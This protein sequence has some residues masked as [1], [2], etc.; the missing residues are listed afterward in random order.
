ML[1]LLYLDVFKT[2]EVIVLQFPRSDGNRDSLQ[3]ALVWL[4][5]HVKEICKNQTSN[6]Q[7]DTFLGGQF[8]RSN[9]V[10]SLWT[11]TLLKNPISRW[12]WYVAFF[13]NLGI[14][15]PGCRRKNIADALFAGGNFSNERH[16]VVFCGRKTNFPL[17]R[18]Y[19][20]SYK[21]ERNKVIKI[22]ERS[23]PT[24]GAQLSARVF[25]LPVNT[26]FVKKK[27]TLL[28]Y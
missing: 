24:L 11:E 18:R 2:F 13:S 26:C 25:L 21:R 16:S 17:V 1:L 22:L 28:L 8:L 10:S 4:T 7:R 9:P 14:L 12:C 6:S 27:S 19:L 23:Q 20:E 15:S 5:G 3:I